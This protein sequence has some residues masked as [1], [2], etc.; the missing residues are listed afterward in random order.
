MEFQKMQLIKTSQGSTDKVYLQPRIHKPPSLLRVVISCSL[1]G[2]A[3]C[4]PSKKILPK[5]GLKIGSS[6]ADFDSTLME[7][8]WRLNGS[9][10][11]T[12]LIMRS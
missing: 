12:V 1:L 3:P 11:P 7:N 4:D 10:G 5:E 6:E 9:R 2:K 8:N